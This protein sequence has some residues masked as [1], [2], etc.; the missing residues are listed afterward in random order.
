MPGQRK[1]K[2]Q[3]QV[4][5][6]RYAARFADREGR[7]EVLFETQDSAEFRAYVRQLR[8]SEPGLDESAVRVD[9]LCGRLVHPTSY[10]LSRFVPAEG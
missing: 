1:R 4:E 6:E 9:T 5:A 3:Q 8:V 10:R 2:R 7:W